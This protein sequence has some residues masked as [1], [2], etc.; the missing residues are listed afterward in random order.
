MAQPLTEKSYTVILSAVVDGKQAET[1]W[2][3][4]YDPVSKGAPAASDLT[5][6]PKP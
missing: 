4:N 3:F 6:P 1:R 2:T 5:A